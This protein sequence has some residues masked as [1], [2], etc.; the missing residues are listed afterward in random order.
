LCAANFN[1][2]DSRPPPP[3]STALNTGRQ[4][5]KFFK[6]LATGNDGRVELKK[7]SLD[8][9]TKTIRLEVNIRA[10]HVW[11]IGGRRIVAFSQTGNVSAT[12]SL[13]PPG[14]DVRVAGHRFKFSAKELL[15][16]LLRIV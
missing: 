9:R 3:F 12:A 5:E 1:R 10:K 11:K 2:P 14:I 8:S 13:S 7:L 4:V 15:T 6:T 16:L